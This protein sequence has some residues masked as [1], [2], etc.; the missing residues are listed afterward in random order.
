MSVEDGSSW[1]E[2]YVN[3][4]SVR[5]ESIEL[6]KTHTKFNDYQ[7]YITGDSFIQADEVYFNETLGYWVEKETKLKTLH[8]GYSSGHHYNI[9]TIYLL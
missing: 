6:M 4:S 7:V 8:H 3:K 9:I 5:V 1:I 2:N